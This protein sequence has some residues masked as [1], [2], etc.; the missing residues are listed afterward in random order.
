MTGVGSVPAGGGLLGAEEEAGSDDGEEAAALNPSRKLGVGV[1]EFFW[2]A[3]IA[4]VSGMPN[5][6]FNDLGITLMNV[7][8]TSENM[9]LVHQYR[10]T[11]C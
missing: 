1:V 7:P 4:L 3:L 5:R 11:A 9:L 10:N 8:Q 6:A 2:L